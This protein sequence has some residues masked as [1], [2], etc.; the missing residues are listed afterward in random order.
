MHLYRTPAEA[1]SWWPNVS[2]HRRLIIPLGAVSAVLRPI[3]E[4]ASAARARVG[5]GEGRARELVC[6][7]T[8]W[9]DGGIDRRFGARRAA[10]IEE[11]WPEG[12][13]GAAR[14]IDG[15]SRRRMC[16]LERAGFWFVGVFARGV[17]RDVSTCAPPQGLDAMCQTF[18]RFAAEE[19]L[20]AAVRSRSPERKPRRTRRRRRRRMRRHGRGHARHRRRRRR[21]WRCERLRRGAGAG[22]RAGQGAR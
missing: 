2:A 21:Y 16:A 5:G 1:Q 6:A 10:G 9:D 3:A 18:A 22:A 11:R 19:H 15:C 14:G 17:D 8:G 4:H 13:G 12:R 20:S 7:Q